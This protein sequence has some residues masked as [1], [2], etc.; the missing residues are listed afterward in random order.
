MRNAGSKAPGRCEPRPPTL[1][2]AQTGGGLPLQSARYLSWGGPSRAGGGSLLCPQTVWIPG[3]SPA[4][5]PQQPGSLVTKGPKA[6]GRGLVC[7]PML[8]WGPIPQPC[9]FLPSGP[10]LPA[11]P[12]EGSDLTS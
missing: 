10:L 12:K 6:V 1:L 9:P 4:A 2:N 5:K 3:P 8:V 7:N 11:P